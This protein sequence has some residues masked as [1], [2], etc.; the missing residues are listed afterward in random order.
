MCDLGW[1]GCEHVGSVLVCIVCVSACGCRCDVTNVLF[2]CR[3][4][5]LGL[6]MSLEVLFYE[7][8]DQWC[9]VLG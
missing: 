4:R 5:D 7:S 1:F 2:M 6:L 8:G 3:N 9:W